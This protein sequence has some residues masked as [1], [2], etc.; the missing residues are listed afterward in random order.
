M[1]R[2]PASG[3]RGLLLSRVSSKGSFQRIYRDSMKGSFKGS[4]GLIVRVL[5]KRSIGIRG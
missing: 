3:S 5:F 2:L 1:R 4:I